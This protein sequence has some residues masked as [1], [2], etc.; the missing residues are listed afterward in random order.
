[1][2]MKRNTTAIAAIVL[3][4]CVLTTS[5]L[6]DVITGSG[7]MSLKDS[8]K[9]T[10]KFVTEQADSYTATISYTLKEGNKIYTK[11]ENIEKRDFKNQKSES[12]SNT[13][14]DNVS[15]DDYSGYHY[16]DSKMNVHENDEGLYVTMYHNPQEVERGTNPFNDEIMQDVEKV[17]DAFVGTLQDIIQTEQKDGK[18]MYICNADS[19]QIP[20]YINALTSFGIKYSL[21]EEYNI[22]KWQLPQIRNDIYVSNAS[23]KICANENDVITDAVLVGELKGKEKNGTEH[24]FQLEICFSLTDINA[25]EIQTPDITNAE[26][27][28]ESGSV[29][30]YSMSLPSTDI[31]KYTSPQTDIVDGKLVKT[32]EYVL[33]ITDISESSATGRFASPD[34]F[35]FDFTAEFSKNEDSFYGAKF[36][37]QQNGETKYGVLNK[38]GDLNLTIDLDVVFDE[39]GIANYMEPT[40][41]F[42]RVFE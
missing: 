26:I 29:S 5:A 30:E 22:E 38:S 13:T 17:A 14:S 41:E 21:F 20:I 15:T 31:G 33:E 34:G 16:S 8:L 3:G 40:I 42:N 28:Y 7:Y 4:L 37:Y 6:A 27:Y 19:S 1:M 23:A 32:G 18:T 11:A 35:S 2:K 39:Q 10:A 12:I 36:E 9:T 25:T 24:T